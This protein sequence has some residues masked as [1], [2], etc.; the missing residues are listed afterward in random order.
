MN[1]SK[2]AA[3]RVM[4]SEEKRLRLQQ[5]LSDVKDEGLHLLMRLKQMLD[6]KV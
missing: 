2:E 6:V 4:A 5:E 3:Y 1:V